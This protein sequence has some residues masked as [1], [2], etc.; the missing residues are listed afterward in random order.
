M[1]AMWRKL[2]ILT[3]THSF[4]VASVSAASIALSFA[5]QSVSH[6]ET[7]LFRNLLW[8]DTLNP[9]I[10]FS[11][12]FIGVVPALLGYYHIGRLGFVLSVA[13]GFA[14]AWIMAV[15]AAL[16]FL[17]VGHYFGSVWLG[18]ICLCC[19]RRAGVHVH[20]TTPFEGRKVSVRA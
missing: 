17:Y 16:C 12:V 10:T 8:P 9:C 18:A 3:P 1:C 14:L 19:V 11:N 13:A 2:H 6:D 5:L 15:C 4:V 7:A 20:G